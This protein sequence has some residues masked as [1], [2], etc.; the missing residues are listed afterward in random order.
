MSWLTAKADRSVAGRETMNR[1]LELAWEL[2][3]KLELEFALEGKSEPPA[4][5]KQRGYRYLETSLS[6]AWQM[7]PGT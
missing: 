2:T 6:R 4:A 1:K 7:V 5:N 3:S